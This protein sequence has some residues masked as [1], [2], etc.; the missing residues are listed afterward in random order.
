LPQSEEQTTVRDPVQYARFS[1]ERS[2]PFFQ[3]LERIPQ[4][5][6]FQSIV[7]LGCGSGE[8][9]RAIAER[10]PQAHVLGLDY[11]PQ[12]LARS[13]DYVLPGR[14]EFVEGNIEDYERP[15]DL[16]FANAALQWVANHPV[17]FPRLAGLVNPG[18]VLAVQMPFSHVQR[19]HELMEE[20]ARQGPWAAKLAEWRRFQVQPLP[21][22][23]E[24]MMGLGFRV[25]AWETT[26][27]FVLQG[28]DP[29]LEW[30]KGTSLQPILSVLSE[31]ER[32]QFTST[33]AAR[34][35]EAYPPTPQGTIYAF[36][37]IFFVAIRDS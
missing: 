26:Y 25:D 16:I 6:P 10:W 22:Y 28:A 19:S 14:L 37:R 33:Y 27:Y 15:A 11:S 31:E 36:R 5:L 4:Q 2:R 23:I 29:V 9:T 21:W 17:V 12:M 35:R 1:D 13:G 34:L 3:L 24:L 30:V 20:T 7:D 32:L 8:L 18:G